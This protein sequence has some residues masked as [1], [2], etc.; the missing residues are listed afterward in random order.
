MNATAAR[1][2][3]LRAG[4][5]DVTLRLT[6]AQQA[7]EHEGPD[8]ETEAQRLEAVTTAALAVA[9]EASRL[10]LNARND[11]TRFLADLGVLETLADRVI[12]GRPVLGEVDARVFV[13]RELLGIAMEAT[14]RP[15]GEHA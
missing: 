13:V 7:H 8:S 3:L 11:D 6:R 14:Y 5:A 1:Y 12:D 2:Q 15:G 4:L 10:A 9:L